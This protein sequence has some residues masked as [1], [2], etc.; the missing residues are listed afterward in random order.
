M[1]I[2][3]NFNLIDKEDNEFWTLLNKILREEYNISGH[4]L[5][6]PRSYFIVKCILVGLY[7]KKVIIKNKNGL[8]K[9]ISL[10]IEK[11]NIPNKQELLKIWDKNKDEYPYLEQ[12]LEKLS[13]YD[14]TPYR[15]KDGIKTLREWANKNFLF[16]GFVK[17][18]PDVD[19]IAHSV[20]FRCEQQLRIKL[21]GGHILVN[22]NDVSALEFI[23]SHY[24]PES[25][26]TLYGR[27]EEIKN[28]IEINKALFGC[29]INFDYLE[30]E[31][32]ELILP[33]SASYDGVMISYNIKKEPITLNNSKVLEMV[34]DDGF[35]II[36]NYDNTQWGGEQPFYDY[37]VPLMID[38]G[39]SNILVVRKIIDETFKVR[40]GQVYISSP[41]EEDYWIEKLTKCIQDGVTTHYYQ[42]LKKED[43]KNTS[44]FKFNDVKRLPDQLNFVWKKKSEIYSIVENNEEWLYNTDI[45]N[46]KIIIGNTVNSSFSSNPFKTNTEKDIYLHNFVN[47]DVDEPHVLERCE[48]MRDNDYDCDYRYTCY[49]NDNEKDLFDKMYNF[50][51]KVESKE[52]IDLDRKLC[53][54]ILTSPCLLYNGHKGVLRVNASKQQPVCF[55]KYFFFFNDDFY[56]IDCQRNCDVIEIKPEY[57]ENFIIY[58]LV[59]QKYEFSDYLLV[60][61]TKEEQHTYFLNKRLDYLSDYQQVVDE[62]EDELRKSIAESHACITG[63]G[64]KNFRRFTNLRPKK[65][66]GVNIFVGGNNSGKSTLV[67][68]LLLALDNLKGLTI[69]NAESN[70]SAP[71]F[72][73][74][75]NGIHDLHVGTF[76]RAYSSEAKKDKNDLERRCMEFII[77]CAHFEITFSL[78]PTYNGDSPSVPI[79]KI[80]V[81]DHKRNATF[82]FDY[83]NVR[84]LAKF[85]IGSETVDINYSGFT[86]NNNPKLGDNQIPTLIRSIISTNNPSFFKD[87]EAQLEKLKGKSGFILE[88]ADELERVIRNVNVEYIYAHGISQKVL[89]NFNDRNDY[90]A[91]TLHDLLLE[92]IGKVEHEFICKWLSAFGIGT[93]YDIRTIGGEAY[94]IQVKK[95]KDKMV[96]LADMGM[97]SNQLVILILRLAIFI[98]KQRMRGDTPYNPT[99]IIE[100][101][102]QNMHPAFQSKLADLFFEVNKEYG[103]NFIVETHSE[104]VVRKTQ[105]I[106]AQQKY[107]SE[108]K[109]K[110]N[111]PFKVYYFPSDGMPYEMKYRTD[112]NFSNE[113]GKGFYDEANNL[114]FEII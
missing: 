84:T 62:M 17:I 23:I 9:D 63:V 103:F 3:E 32:D 114:L 96:Y 4:H 73:F 57:D 102:E 105:V 111:N 34:K 85:K 113:F 75:A 54:R 98:H 90:M 86:V 64:F 95:G 51:G 48:I 8:S 82:A 88:I 65:I 109:L 78:V 68:G 61:P 89:F 100:E 59:K 11:S 101:P 36:F 112:G 20:I 1:E 80:T 92:R 7:Y 25:R 14:F 15:N 39:K 50:N 56:G 38:A 41:L 35:A 79:E 42:E 77:S 110:A 93:D 53:C 76:N 58:Q 21:N 52:E 16:G 97:G 27:S 13:S 81:K 87:K 107:T 69:E 72:Q 5:S 26:F 19:N 94:I 30:A 37:E 22:T 45:E 44:R 43:F 12:F 60:A 46:D 70:I 31:D 104:Y 10:C 108:A 6:S 91:Q 106:V 24:S 83:R 49:F 29:C 67:K 55:E 66:G 40:Y 71:K 74:D 2:I 28:I 18:R 47:I 99:I 33:H